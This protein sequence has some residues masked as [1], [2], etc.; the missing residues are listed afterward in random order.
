MKSEL[1]PSKFRKVKLPNGLPLTKDS[2][3]KI[4]L[5]ALYQ[6]LQNNPIFKP[7]YDLDTNPRQNFVKIDIINL[8]IN[9]CMW[10]YSNG[11]ISTNIGLKD[12]ILISLIDFLY[13]LYGR[14]T[15]EN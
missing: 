13:Q 11:T 15:L 8:N 2:G 6:S 5:L 9:G 10:I 1:Q 3:K 4:N 14:D 12:E 7:Q